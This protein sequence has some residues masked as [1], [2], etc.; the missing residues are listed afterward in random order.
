M[1]QELELIVKLLE[2]MKL[3]NNTSSEEFGRL[4]ATIETKLD[5]MKESTATTELIKDYLGVIVK[6][7][8]ER[9]SITISKFDSIDKVLKPL[10]EK[11]NGHGKNKNL[12][13]SL[14]AYTENLNDF[15]SKEQEQKSILAHIESQLTDIDSS[16]NKDD[17]LKIITDIQNSFSQL[18]HDYKTSVDN[19]YYNLKSIITTLNKIDQSKISNPEKEHINTIY[20]ETDGI[21]SYLKSIEKRD[22]HLEKL[23]SNVAANES[24][25]F[26]QGVIDSIIEKSE[27][28]AEKITNLADKSAIEELQDAVDSLNQKT[29]DSV[30]KKEF[31]KITLKTEDL[32]KQTDEVKQTLATVT[33]NIE[34]LPNTKLLE[35]SLQTLFKKL[36]S[37]AQDIANL[38]AKGEVY[39]LDTKI[40]T[41]KDELITI[42]NIIVDL[43][44]VITSKVLS[45]I[46]DISFENEKY[47]IKNHISKMLAQLPQ[48]EDIEKII[49][50]S[51]NNNNVINNLVENLQDTASKDDIKNLSSKADEIEEMID[52]LNFDDE[53]KNIYNKTASIEE[54]LLKSKIK[55]SSE[56]LV[57][58]L[59][60]KAEQSDVLSILDTTKQIAD[61]L[62]NLAQKPDTENINN[63]ILNIHNEID[64]LKNSFLNSS[65]SH[66]D[67]IINQLSELQESLDLMV[68][69]EEF[70]NFTENLKTFINKTPDENTGFRKEMEEYKKYRESILEKLDNINPEQFN[71]NIKSVEDKV[72][73]IS[74]RLNDRF[75]INT[76]DF[77]EQISDKAE[78]K[79]VLLI[80]DT[81]KQIV[82]QLSEISQKPDADSIGETLSNIYTQIEELKN[83]F[84]NTTGLH[85]E[86]IIS[87]M[88]EL[89]TSISEIVTGNEFNNF[90]DNLKDFTQKILADSD[91]ISENIEENQ[92]LQQSIIEKL[93]NTDFSKIV[94]SINNNMEAFSEGLNSIKSSNEEIS[95]RVTDIENRLI[96]ISEYLNNN[97]NP[98]DDEVK[99][100][101]S[102]IKEI[103]ENKKS[104]FEGIESERNL[105]ID[106]VEK[107]LEEI[108]NI[109][110]TS[111][112]GI[113][114]EVRNQLSGIENE[115][116][117]YKTFSENQFAKIIDKLNE[118]ELLSTNEKVPVENLSSSVT[119]IS[120]IKD[121]IQKLGESFN[122][123]N[124]EK[125][126]TEEEI[127]S[128]VY[129]KL[130]E[131]SSNL[132]DLTINI[133]NGLQQ[134]FA[135]NAE[136]IE[137][138]SAVL[139]DFIK[140][141]RHAST[142]NIE[143]FER[144]TVTDNKLMDFKQELELINTDVIS[145]LNSK[146]DRLI[147]E[148]GPIK[149]MIAC[150]AVQT[151]EGPQSE[152]VKEQLGIL[153]ES[154][155]ED[156]TE[157]TK[158]AKSTF[159]K[160]EETYNQISNNLTSTENN[161]RDFILGDIDSVIIKI[162]NL[163]A[164]L[165]D[166]LNRI[167]PPEAEKMEEFHKFVSEIN[168]FK[169]DQ[170][171][172]FSEIAEDIKTSINE[173]M[174][175]QHDEIKSMLTVAMNNEEIVR[176]IDNLKRCFK[177]K[178]KEL[179]RIQK[180]NSLKNNH[181]DEFGTN[182]YEEVFEESENVKIIAE[183]KEDFNKF[184]GLIN[185]LSGEN[186]EI[187]EVLN[188]IRE[189]IDT[190]TVVKAEKIK[191]ENIILEEKDF[192][193][194]EIEENEESEI[195]IDENI[196]VE[197]DID[198]D[199]DFDEDYDDEDDEILVGV[200]NF[201]FI[202]AFDLLKQDIN[203]LRSDVER[204]LPKDKPAIPTL[205]QGN[206]L[207]SLNNK[208]EL[209]SKT[210][211]KDWLEEIKGYLAGSEIHSMLEEI[212]GKIDIL[213]LSDNSEW[214]GEIKQALEQLNSSDIAGGDANKEIQSTLA[215]INEK[216]DIL[217]SS[218]DYDLMEEVRDAIEKIYEDDFE[219]QSFQNEEIKDK[220]NTLD[221]KVDILASSDNYD[222]IEDIK[223]SLEVL[224]AKID[225]L[226][227]T[228]NF[229]QIEEI[230]DSI[231]LLENKIDSVGNSNNYDSI[232]NIRESLELIES[233]IEA[234]IL[235][236]SSDNIEDIKYTLLD[237]EEK[238]NALKPVE[239]QVQKLSEAVDEKVQKLS[240]SDAKITSM[241]EIL[242]HKIDIIS[243]SEESFNTQEDIEDVKHLIL[244]QMDYI[245]NLE[246]N[247]KTEA[248]KKCLKELTLEVNNLNLNSNSSNK[249]VQKTLKDMKESIM[250]AVVTI[251]E[252]VSFIEETE[253][254]KDFVE[255]KTDVINQN[256][257]AVTKQ[258]RQIT[259]S[260][261]DP[262]YTYSMQDIESDLAKL[263]LALNEL[264]NNELETQSSELSHIS[265]NLYRIT[266]SVEELQSS[267]TQDE[268]K[269]LKSDITNLREQTNK[270]LISSDQSYNALN[271]GLEDF[272]KIITTQITNKVDK[273]TQ[274]L[275]K[276]NDSDKVMRQAL[277]Y[278]GEWIDSASES[279]DK[280]STNS[281]EIG[282][283]KA[284]IES[285]KTSIPEQTDILN[286]IEEKFDEQQERL[287]FFEKQITKL[288]SLEDKFEEQ[289]SRID[290]LEMTIEK[291]LS[292]VQDIDD[293]KITRKID[294][295]DKQIAKLS[296]NI[297]K[298][299]SYVD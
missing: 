227:S 295:I 102:E 106:S 37:L 18:N 280:I 255:E 66:K 109:L 200:N 134:G 84:L 219:S 203:N 16:E 243:S 261:E 3:V 297:E 209:L 116:I 104:N 158:Y 24:L 63:T 159:D 59:P 44:E 9:T 180:E 289:Q 74:E 271:S 285:L 238:I 196:E 170:K 52:N 294:K 202:K 253:D 171:A 229:E 233:K 101:I 205:G 62:S 42:K 279:M 103:V 266:S 127:S 235:P 123:L 14:N 144:L 225:T 258:L 82:E 276:S 69:M 197:S 73:Y 183:I 286:S 110:D 241:L 112:N 213:T 78:Q 49:I 124:C 262:D 139:L 31:A 283:M 4:L 36:D 119:E 26:T 67:N 132:G 126:S 194:S 25:K 293:S 57:A 125:G 71:K 166:T 120:E 141:L 167:A 221:Q 12:N 90:V 191:Q 173:K 28:I 32:V 148:L 177:S 175:V 250:A 237:V 143:L 122:A 165:E 136:L 288:G 272:S 185:D 275:E 89:Q 186:P 99:I 117:N 220:L 257:E 105:T 96:T 91:K 204:V 249:Q 217:A 8:D 23:I 118:Y 299:A 137:E 263:R 181:L 40:N 251:F 10:L 292:A 100:A 208:I 7:V 281:D 254:I 247:N 147:K 138:K 53:F 133:E 33:Q 242:N 70:S 245:E 169:E 152:K 256:L 187:E 6:T 149:E 267:L 130:E 38:D 94:N 30:S 172:F 98:N 76:D 284:A 35:E 50:E 164:D 55:E 34:T 75:E 114:E 156:I 201:E 79:D 19:L 154:V 226:T 115:L 15:I 265:D 21:V 239:E 296:I 264:Q 228:D 17:I 27:E 153:H 193:D 211:N 162:D 176:A 93:E 61:Q 111:D 198:T 224:D 240:E 151:P 259:N 188:S 236:D 260:N 87:S 179:S 216:I 64:E 95:A 51:E 150:M 41:L 60:N 212:S 13:K 58:Q 269:E 145:D 140:E 268:I 2:E 230:R 107:Y 121:Q 278:M 270:L 129:E 163:R 81:T 178:I 1:A 131:L 210:L 223:E 11:Q 22:S 244:A 157:C 192:T 155:Q 39:D 222:S 182:Q 113:S 97:L 146:T 46:K 277:I 232:E 161:L 206:M 168:T 65:E 234:I 273:V 20:K 68:S 248:F 128:F 92:K 142:G 83:D 184:S 174:T 215:L 207:M 54:W 231:S 80:L 48:K 290:R 77:V 218:D 252:Q 160:L 282:D 86:A 199:D 29:D 108:K 43:N 287:S 47:D 85:S 56:E 214:I 190:I 246:H 135:Y 189:K 195:D 5:L 274:L 88:S 72:D 45:G 298:L 291:V